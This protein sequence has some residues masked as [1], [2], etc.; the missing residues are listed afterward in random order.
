MY[1]SYHWRSCSPE[2][3][4]GINCVWV[5]GEYYS[6]QLAG[7][8]IHTLLS[9]PHGPAHSTL[10]PVVHCFLSLP[11]SFISQLNRSHKISKSEE[12]RNSEKIRE[13]HRRRWAALTLKREGLVSISVVTVSSWISCTSIWISNYPQSL[14]NPTA[15]SRKWCYFL[16]WQIQNTLKTSRP[17]HFHYTS[18]LPRVHIQYTCTNPS[19]AFSHHTVTLSTLFFSS[20]LSCHTNDI[21]TFS[22]CLTSHH[23]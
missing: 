11:A 21:L 23:S 4:T 13:V 14:V 5:Y 7:P 20:I 8:F 16:T 15:M 1:S 12:K 3:Q 10:Q 18:I 19:K 6:W 2:G 9:G 17:A 22:L